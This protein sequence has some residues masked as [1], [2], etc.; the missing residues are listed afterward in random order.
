MELLRIK[1]ERRLEGSVAI[2]G[3]K[4]AAMPVMAAASLTDPAVEPLLAK[5]EYEAEV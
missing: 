2:S 1:G 5:L 4:N 3:S